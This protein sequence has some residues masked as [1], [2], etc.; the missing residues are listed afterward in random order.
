MLVPRFLQQ[1][2]N[3][4]VT[5]IKRRIKP[6]E[7]VDRGQDPEQKRKNQKTREGTYILA[8]LF[9]E[10]LPTLRFRGDLA[11]HKIQ[12]NR[13]A[14]GYLGSVSDRQGKERS[15]GQRTKIN[16]NKIQGRN[17]SKQGQS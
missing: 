1:T 9:K 10:N 7:V 16:Q 13:Q 8:R 6:L 4:G 3:S 15:R 14:E 17:L 12:I 2:R 5:E 11:K